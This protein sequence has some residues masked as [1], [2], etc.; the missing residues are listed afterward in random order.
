MKA[1]AAAGE[2]A[3]IE[4]MMA[5]PRWRYE[6]RIRRNRQGLAYHLRDARFK[7]PHTDLVYEPMLELL[8]YLRAN[9]FKTYI[10]SGGGIEF[11]RRSPKKHMASRPS[12]LWQQHRYQV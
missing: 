10:V 4:L 1:L 12:R 5:T 6:R 3:F 9:D 2:P 7:R 11:M 8:T